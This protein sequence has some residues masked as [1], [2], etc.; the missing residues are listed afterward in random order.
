[1][2]LSMPIPDGKQIWKVNKELF[3]EVAFKDNVAVLERYK[4]QSFSKTSP[5]TIKW[6]NAARKATTNIIMRSQCAID[7]LDGRLLA[8]KHS[9]EWNSEELYKLLLSVKNDLAQVV[10]QNRRESIL[11]KYDEMREEVLK[12]ERLFMSDDLVVKISNLTISAM[13]VET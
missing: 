1:M 12:R 2:K 8:L 5:T 11:S 4:P 13:K 6:L 3:V 9:N 10:V 7:A